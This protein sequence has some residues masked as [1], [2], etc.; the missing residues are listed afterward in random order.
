MKQASGDTAAV[1]TYLLGEMEDLEKMKASMGDTTKEDHKQQIDNFVLSVFAKTDKEERTCAEI[2][3]KNAMDFKRC[4]DFIQLLTLFGA[5]EPE[6]AERDKYCKYKAGTILKALKNGEQPPRG[7]PF[8]P[9]EEEEKKQ[10]EVNMENI[11]LEEQPTS[12]NPPASGG[13]PYGEP[14]PHFL[15]PMNPTQEKKPSPR[16]VH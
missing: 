1:K 6:W 3:K 9:P 12:I 10:E 11:T 13:N 16:Q 8:A 15:P 7:N 4:T 5:L 2:T 14:K